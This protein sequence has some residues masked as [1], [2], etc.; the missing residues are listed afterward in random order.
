MSADAKGPKADTAAE[1]DENK[2]DDSKL[3]AADSHAAIDRFAKE[4]GPELQKSLKETASKMQ[5]AFC[6]MVY[7]E[8][9]NISTEKSTIDWKNYR[10]L[11]GT[12]DAIDECKKQIEENVKGDFEVVLR[13]HAV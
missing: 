4:V 10:V 2:T 6:V 12:Q 9:Y 8:S 13:E 1:G 7:E 5:R 3:T 11:V